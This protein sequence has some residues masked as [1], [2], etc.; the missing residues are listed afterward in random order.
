LR[1]IDGIPY[2]QIEK[3]HGKIKILFVISSPLDLKDHERLQIEKEQTLI[4]QAVDRAESANRIEITFED[5]AS[6]RNIQTLLDEE[7]YHILHYTGHGLYSEKEDKG[8]LLLEDDSGKKRLVDND[9]VAEL[10]AGYSS[11]RLV[12]LSGCQTAKT[13]GR[14]SLSDLSTPLLLGGIPSVVSMQYSV[15]DSS[16]TSFTEKFYTEL[17]SGTPIDKALTDARKQLYLNEARGTVDFATPVLYSDDPD[18]LCT[19]EVKPEVLKPGFKFDKEITYKQNIVLAL[20]QLGTQFI[21]R[22]KELRRIKEDF[23]L[24]RIRAVVLHGIGGIGKTVISTK[25]AEKIEKQFNGIYAFNCGSGLKIEEVLI[26]LNEFLKRIDVNALDEV[27]T[28][29]APINIKINYLAQLLTQVKLLLLFDNFESLL[30]EE[31][32][33]WELT[34]TVLKNNLKSLINQ[35]KEGTRFIFTSRNTFNLTDGRITGEIDE[36]NIGELSQPEAIMVM[37]RFP[38]IAKEN[39]FTKLDIYKKIGG[40][41]YTINIFGKHARI[42][43]VEEVLK[44]IA[45]VNRDMVEFT[46]LD[47][48]YEAL[49]ENARNLITRTA[50][51]KKSVPLSALKWM[52]K[53]N[54]ESPQIDNEI[55]EL[56]HWGLIIKIEDEQEENYQV[57]TLVKDFIKERI[58]NQ[59]WKKYL[60]K[61]AGY[62]EDLAEKTKILWDHLDACELYFTAGEY[63]KAGEIVAIITEYLHRWG[64]IDL[65]KAL[66][67]QTVNTSSG[68]VKARALHNLG[69]IYQGQGEY[70]KALE[71]YNES[72]KISKELGYKEGIAV[73]LHELGMIHLNQGE[74]DKA[75]KKYNVSLK[76]SKELGDKQGISGTLHQLGM[77]Y[78]DQGEYEKAVEKYNESLKISGKLGDK[79]GI[80]NALHEL[81]RIHQT[82][83][84]YDK[85]LKK[86]NESLKINKELGNKRGIAYTLGQLGIIYHDQGEYKKALEKYNECL[87]ISEKLGDKQSIANALHQLGIIYHD[88][89]EYTK[90][91]EKYN[92]SLKIS[93]E[94][95]DKK[96]IANA[97]HQLG[98]MHYHQAKY[99]EAVEKY[100][101]SLKISKELGDKQGIAISL[102]QLGMIYQDQGE[103]EKAVEKYNES[104]KISKELGD[105]QGIAISLHQLGNIHY[106]QGEYE[107]SLEK[108]NESLK[109]NK[110]LGD[111]EGIALTL[112]Q[113]GRIYEIK[114]EYKNALRN[115]IFAYN[116]FEYLKS[117]DKNTVVNWIKKLKEKIGK[118]TF[119][120][121]YNEIME[122]PKKGEN[123]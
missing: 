20:E 50:V 88:Q 46:L 2:K 41:P 9:T 55:Q 15:A 26:Q 6:L 80:A 81:G 18:C 114:K 32:G 60:I 52:V 23:F 77:I 42:K 34:D 40:H 103:Y 1:V 106:Q 97:L 79:Q 87:K 56:I 111:K 3:I 65:V 119:E 10:L 99:T 82:Q 54:G 67:E 24:R 61:A 102:H 58:G 94:L 4:H 7:K 51:F 35:C 48:S 122:E 44:D 92:E 47:K 121:Y 85:A 28:S 78:H 8:Y 36:I 89:G 74:Y 31:G 109:I 68:L 107:K 101:E 118:K 57:H 104:L 116:I 12:F 5:E 100:N 86:Y 96:G 112:G 71:K 64:F 49:S 95:G 14:K 19:E 22:R 39:F 110:E 91:V 90:A 115:Y 72:L 105:K 108:Y 73:T 62:Y 70:E 33:K 76:I 25:I 30:K 117:P 113:L 27:V 69:V 38:E 37:N 120:K 83:G 123:G 59:E 53:N 11:L 93:K 84:E 75:L 43:S 45:H 13:S 16:A 66:N 21:G 63:D 98:N 17:S 29:R